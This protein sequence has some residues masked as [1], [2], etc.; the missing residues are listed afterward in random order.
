MDGALLVFSALLLSRLLPPVRIAWVRG[1]VG[2]YLMLML[3]CGLG[4]IAN[5]FWL[6][7]VV[8]RGWTGW[9]IPD[10][11]T[12]KASLAWAVIVVAAAL[13]WRLGFERSRRAAA[14]APR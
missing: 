5:D 6:E 7:Q 2:A 10:V 12:P 3:C 14:L 9:E 4:N 1:L 8:K 13:L 11:T